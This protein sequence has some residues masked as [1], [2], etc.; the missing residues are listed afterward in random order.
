MGTNV[1]QTGSFRSSPA[2][3]IVASRELAWWLGLVGGGG[4]WI[5]P[6]NS[7]PAAAITARATAKNI[8]SARNSNMNRNIKR[9]PKAPNSYSRNNYFFFV[10]LVSFFSPSGFAYVVATVPPIVAIMPFAESANWPS[11]AYC[12]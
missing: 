5:P 6:V 8:S 2:D 9:G 1:P 10:F 7:L 3:C 11:G 12:R 4:A